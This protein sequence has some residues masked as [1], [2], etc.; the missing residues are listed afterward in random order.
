M[1]SDEPN[2]AEHAIPP[3]LGV[4]GYLRWAGRCL[5]AF[6]FISA[7]T[8]FVIVFRSD[9]SNLFDY[10]IGT[11][12][13]FQIGTPIF[14]T[15]WVAGTRARYGVLFKKIPGTLVDIVLGTVS[16]YILGFVVWAL[17]Y[18]SWFEPAS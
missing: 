6:A 1:R 12:V 13:I 10:G 14:V 9:A 11:Y 7:M 3:S 18:N 17:I 15:L 4:P 16:N 5:P 2:N 8:F